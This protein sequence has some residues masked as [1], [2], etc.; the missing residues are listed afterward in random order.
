MS[1]VSESTGV[2]HGLSVESVVLERLPIFY[3]GAEISGGRKMPFP[4]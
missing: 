4:R 2:G 3:A 1:C